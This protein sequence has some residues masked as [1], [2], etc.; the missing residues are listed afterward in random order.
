MTV[1]CPEHREAIPR[2]T[3]LV[4]FMVC[5][6]SSSAKL[7]STGG[8]GSEPHRY[9]RCYK[10]TTNLR[11]LKDPEKQE[12]NVTNA[13]HL[14]LVLLCCMVE[15]SACLDTLM[16]FRHHLGRVLSTCLW[17]SG[18]KHRLSVCFPWNSLYPLSYPSIP[19][20]VSIEIQVR[21]VDVPKIIKLNTWGLSK[22]FLR[23][24]RPL[25]ATQEQTGAGGT[26]RKR[27]MG[28]GMF[29]SVM[30]WATQLHQALALVWAGTA[31]TM[32]QNTF[33]FL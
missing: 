17:V 3:S 29:P 25:Q 20:L 8:P 18:V 31:K 6:R 22:S 1:A 2:G 32:I 5:R 33:L 16:E 12:V 7:W 4:R 28:T 19:V 13:A 21:W 30:A 27:T 11:W 23:E 15:A 10:L 24:D 14:K 9:C 26:T